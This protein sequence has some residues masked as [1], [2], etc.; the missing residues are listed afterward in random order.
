[1]L[2]VDICDDLDDYH[3]GCDR[4][5]DWFLKQVIAVLHQLIIILTSMNDEE[6]VITDDHYCVVMPM[7]TKASGLLTRMWAKISLGRFE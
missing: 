6:R 1:M 3:L 4:N 2:P 5:G 7:T